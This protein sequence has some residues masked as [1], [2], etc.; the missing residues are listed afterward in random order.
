MVAKKTAVK[1][2]T[3]KKAGK[4]L[5]KSSPGNYTKPELREKIK[6]QV[7]AGD[8][9]GRPG[10]WSARKAQLLAHEYEAKGGGY[11][12]PRSTAQKSL[13]KWGDEQWHTANGKQAV[14]GGETHRYLPDAA[15]K[16]LSPKQRKATDARKVKASKSGRQYVANTPAASKA[17]KQ[18][19]KQKG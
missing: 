3:A 8:K 4:K 5:S 6:K 11:K 16:K 9:G 19:I 7:L 14:Q 2:A 17:R 10:Q 12:R 18:S 13:K 15:W 1:K